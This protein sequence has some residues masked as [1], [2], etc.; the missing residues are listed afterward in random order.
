MPTAVESPGVLA[1]NHIQRRALLVRRAS[2]A[3]RN[4]RL[5]NLNLIRNV[6]EIGF[7]FGAAALFAF[8]LLFGVG[9]YVGIIF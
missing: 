5:G 2:N 3:S 8:G 7:E 4:R 1:R 6:A 9:M